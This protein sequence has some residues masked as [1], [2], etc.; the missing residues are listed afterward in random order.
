M[1][2]TATSIKGTVSI[3]SLT[4]NK[5]IESSSYYYLSETSNL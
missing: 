5:K 1:Y 2:S 3:F 4:L